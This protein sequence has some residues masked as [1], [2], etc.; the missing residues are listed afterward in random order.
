M[1]VLFCSP[2]KENKPKANT[3]CISTSPGAVETSNSPGQEGF[4]VR[5]HVRIQK[6]PAVRARG[7]SPPR[8]TGGDGPALGLPL[9][10]P[11][12]HPPHFFLGEVEAPRQEGLPEVSQRACGGASVRTPSSRSQGRIVGAELGL[13]PRHHPAPRLWCPVPPR[14]LLQ[15][16]GKETRPVGSITL[17]LPI[18]TSASTRR[19]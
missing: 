16:L 17:P 10:P 3:A 7:E 6:Q 2:R 18:L 9:P 1:F 12:P 11:R 5:L 13:S 15:T 19:P 4:P 8:G 14:C